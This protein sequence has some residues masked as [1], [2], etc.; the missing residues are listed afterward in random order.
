MVSGFRLLGLRFIGCW[1]AAMSHRRGAALA[2]SVEPG[3]LGD[4]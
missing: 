1:A 4:D 2:A 3:R